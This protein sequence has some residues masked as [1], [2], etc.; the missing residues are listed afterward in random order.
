MVDD[1]MEAVLLKS[2]NHI[3]KGRQF[4]GFVFGISSER[5]ERKRGDREGRENERKDTLHNI[6]CLIQLFLK[7][8]R[9]KRADL[10]L[11]Q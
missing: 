8:V 10:L 3:I 6:L 2:W 9:G 11:R 5:R 7:S 4:S 1:L